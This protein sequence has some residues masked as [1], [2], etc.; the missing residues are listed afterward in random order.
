MELSRKLSG[1]LI[2]L[3]FVTNILF[4]CDNNH[5]DVPEDEILMSHETLQAYE[6]P[7]SVY[8]YNGQ[9]TNSGLVFSVEAIASKCNNIGEPIE[10]KLIFQNTTKEPIMIT[11]EFNVINGGVGAGGN[12]TAIISDSR[13]NQI[14]TLADKNLS[15]DTFYFPPNKY[16][17]IHQDA[18]EEFTIDYYFPNKLYKNKTDE[19]RSVPTSGKYLIRFVYSDYQRE[20]DNWEGIVSSNLIT[21]CIQ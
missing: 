10:L 16:S 5:V 1:L 18:V 11:S 7:L 6:T 15:S 9:V 19:T 17:T 3:T 4:S 13:K 14:Y 21:V 2:C 12:L 20:K 8:R